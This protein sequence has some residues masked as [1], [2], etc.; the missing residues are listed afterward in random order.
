MAK[1]FYDTAV[2]IDLL[3]ENQAINEYHFILQLRF[4]NRAFLGRP[5]SGIHGSADAG[6][7]NA[8]AAAAAQAA[9]QRRLSKLYSLASANGGRCP[10]S[11]TAI[12]GGSN[13]D[14]PSAVPTV[15]SPAGSPSPEPEG[16]SRASSAA[17]NVSLTLTN[18][19]LSEHGSI[20][21]PL[22]IHK[23]PP[24]PADVFLEIFPFSIIYDS[25][26]RIRQ[27]GNC[28]QVCQIEQK[29]TLTFVI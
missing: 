24:I 20:T 15:P 6:S 7:A 26:M 27:T 8:E 9:T 1:V 18:S 19:S 21:S 22:A 12:R 17:T 23:M 25:S 10:F 28:L 3:E 2:D 11:G 29:Q 13:L 14:L 4:D 5:A 16:G